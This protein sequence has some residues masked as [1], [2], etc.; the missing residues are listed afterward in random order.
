[1]LFL[2]SAQPWRTGVAGNT[3]NCE[4]PL[5][6][7]LPRAAFSSSSELSSSHGPGFA[8]LNRRDVDSALV[9]VF[10]QGNPV[11]QTWL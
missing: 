2:L 7:S 9:A 4:A 5:A 6:S 3:Y 11:E 10:L 8:S 1:M